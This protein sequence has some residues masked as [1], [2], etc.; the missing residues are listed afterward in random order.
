MA[1]LRLQG[2]INALQAI[3][4]DKATRERCKGKGQPP[5]PRKTKN[6]YAMRSVQGVYPI[7]AV[8]DQAVAFVEFVHD[9]AAAIL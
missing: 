4:L 2:R 6:G 1:S 8:H 7:W 5:R 3:A 9:M